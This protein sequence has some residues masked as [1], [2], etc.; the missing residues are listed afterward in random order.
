MSEYRIKKVGVKGK[1][2]RIKYE[3]EIPSGDPDEFSLLSQDEARPEFH[4]ALKALVPFVLEICEASWDADTVE[5]TGVSFSHVTDV[6]G[7][8]I[9]AQ[10]R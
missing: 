4:Q 9:T 6:M 8:V 1:K 7:A 5:V 3:R 10:K 2:I